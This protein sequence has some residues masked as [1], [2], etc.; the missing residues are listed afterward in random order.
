[1]MKDYFIGLDMGTSSVGWAV[2]NKNYTVSSFNKKKM[3]GI[4]RFEEGETAENRRMARTARRRLDRRKDRLETL[5]EI[6]EP[7]LNAIDPEFLTRLAEGA[8]HR[9]DQSIDN[10]YTLF[11]HEDY[12]DKDYYQEFPT[13]FHLRHALIHGN[14]KFD[15]RLIYLAI[16]HIMKYRGHFLYQGQISE[17]NNIEEALD[18][19]EQAVQNVYDA[20]FFNFTAE[21]L[22]ALKELLQTRQMTKSD[23]QKQL[24]KYTRMKEVGKELRAYFKQ[25]TRL[26]MGL[27]VSSD[28]LL[29]E[30]VKED[31]IKLDFT[32]ENF[33]DDFE[34]NS[35]FSP[36]EKA[37]VYAAKAVFDWLVLEEIRAGEKY[38]SD[39]HVKSYEQHGKDLKELKELIHSIDRE[40]YNKFFHDEEKSKNNY[41]AYVG[42]SQQAVATAED[43]Y[44][45]VKKLLK[46]VKGH[47]E[48][49]TAIQDRMDREIYMPKQRIGSNGVIPHQLH[50]LELSAILKHA[51]NYYPFLKERDETGLSNAEKIK[52]LFT[53]RIP[54][55]IGPLNDA[56]K[57]EKFAW[58]VCKD[59][60]EQRSK[61]YPWNFK[62]KVDIEASAEGFIR[63]MLNECTYLPGEAVLPKHSPL[64]QK[65]LVLNEIN[66]ICIDGTPLTVKQKN[67]L[68]KDLFQDKQQ[69]VSKTTIRK[70]LIYHNYIEKEE[71]PLVT[72]IDQT[73][74]SKLT[75]Y[76]DFK[77]IFGGSMPNQNVQ[78]N[79][80][81]WITL[82]GDAKKLLKEKI[83]ETYPN[84]LTEEQL[85][86]II[87]KN[88]I[89][90]G[91][92][93]EKLLTGIKAEVPNDYIHEPIS[94]I[95]ALEVTNMNLMELLSNQYGFMETIDQLRKDSQPKVKQLDYQLVEDL[96]VSPA[97]RRSIWRSLRIVDEIVKIKKSAPK[98][99]MIEMTREH[100]E[101]GKR[102]KSR[103]DQLL[104]LYRSIKKDTGYLS[105]DELATLEER[106]Q[107]ESESKLKS[108]SLYLY[109]TQ[110]GRCMY[111]G[112]QIHPSEIKSRY[113]IDHIYP[114]SVIKD[115]SFKNMVLVKKTANKEKS[116][117]LKVPDRFQKKMFGHWK[118][119]RDKGLISAEKFERL[120]RKE[121]LTTSELA[122][123]INRQLV[124]TSQ[125]TKAVAEILKQLYPKTQIVYVKSGL[126]SDFRNDP[127]QYKTLG[128]ELHNKYR[129]KLT[130]VRG[131]NDIHHAHDAYLNIVVGNVYHTKFTSNPHNFIQKTGK[132]KYNMRRMFDKDVERN[133]N[134]AWKTGKN[135]TIKKVI[136][137]IVRHDIQSTYMTMDGS[138]Q[139]FDAT[140]QKKDPKK[141]GVY[142]PLKKGLA[143]GKYGGYT[144][145]KIAYH[146][147]VE[148]DRRNKKERWLV[149]IPLYIANQISTDEEALGY[150]IEQQQLVH[151]KVLVS[152][153][154]A[155]N[156][157]IN[158][159]GMLARITGKGG[160]KYVLRKEVQPVFSELTNLVYKAITKLKRT[161][162]LEQFKRVVSDENLKYVYAEFVE[163]SQLDLF[164]QT[165][166]RFT[167][168]LLKGTAKFN[169]LTLSDKANVILEIHKLFASSRM[170][171]NLK[172]IGGAGQAGVDSLGRN[173]TNLSKFEIIYQSITGLFESKIDVME[174]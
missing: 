36:E 13:I 120:S 44:K 67:Q 85:E 171:S 30:H 81:L 52:E 8:L 21:D 151:P 26:M 10:K 117:Q 112:E 173:L 14:K 125:S 93:S 16:H 15:L 20:S 51:E 64:Y 111:T 54:Y 1:M 174:L 131:I 31:R 92:F 163:K 148:H 55:Y 99:I 165:A 75:T 98:K 152:H 141:E 138:G 47:K 77:E 123:F 71:K 135:G 122:G 140:L 60:G 105:A 137:T 7:H 158:K 19:V 53:F 86:K 76:H 57:E 41:A 129:N 12:T 91:R 2:T 109:Y 154:P 56:H 100:G 80:V 74:K 17:D 61:I 153:I 18:L 95:K 97:V 156:Q 39:A 23:K 136:K 69:N 45:A 88:Y 159:E 70:W 119:L 170:T 113:D 90:W 24:E 155:A 9:E 3:W 11:T 168:T 59:Q 62:E 166:G 132:E 108:K 146:M 22:E 66:K 33:E 169:K 145:P 124:V 114:Q 150:L 35:I 139:L 73:V 50:L 118:L 82:F 46:N 126:V 160:K 115:N 28:L 107:H 25:I 147:I 78:E 37:L 79:I 161:E 149:S 121:P 164:E 49:V 68:F 104:E 29:P 106:L 102:T 6:F 142:V 94:I 72:G 144:K 172:L 143:V 27:K 110:L 96:Y 4:H 83:L 34:S 87:R 103:K 42:K 38:L 48:T 43:F 89:G 5:R 134:V 40:T 133:G 101:K 84:A 128:K 167:D 58:I 32:S 130:K 116:D 65:Y 63:N 162:N 127:G 157:L